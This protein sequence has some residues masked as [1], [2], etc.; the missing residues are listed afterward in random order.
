MKAI[1]VLLVI[2]LGLVALFAVQNPGVITVNFLGVSGR[3]SLLVVIVFA[4][5]LGVAVGSLGGLPSSLRRRRR[6]RELEA[7]AAR[8][9]KAAAPPP[10]PVTP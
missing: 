6:I 5:G 9:K 7:D 4:F 10:P 1:L 8:Q 2:V 3:T